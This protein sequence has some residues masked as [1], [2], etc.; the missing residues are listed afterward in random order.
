MVHVDYDTLVRTPK[1]SAYWFGA[2]IA[3]NAVEV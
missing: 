3:A 1:D 2:V